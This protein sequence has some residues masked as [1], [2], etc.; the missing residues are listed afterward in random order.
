MGAVAM[1]NWM[2][3]YLRTI[4]AYRAY[5]YCLPPPPYPKAHYKNGAPQCASMY[6]I[7]YCAHT[8]QLC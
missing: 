2:G 5:C 8:Q 7:L 3:T 1:E 4:Q 6:Y